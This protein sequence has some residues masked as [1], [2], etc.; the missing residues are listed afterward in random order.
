[1]VDETFAFLPQIDTDG[2]PYVALHW[3]EQTGAFTPSAA[4]RAAL[5]L[6]EAAEQ[7]EL[8][9]SMWEWLLADAARDGVD[10]DEARAKAARIIATFRV[11]RE[12]PVPFT[13]VKEV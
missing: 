2:T 12:Q 7:S 5:A 6:L 13:A 3:R 9:H 1:M 11:H 8:E 4:R 10:P